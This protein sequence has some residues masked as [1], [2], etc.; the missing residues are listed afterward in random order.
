[1]FESQ[2]SNE[3]RQIRAL[4]SAI[5]QERAKARQLRSLKAKRARLERALETMRT[6]K[7]SPER[8]SY[9]DPR[10]ETTFSRPKG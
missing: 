6:P 2:I 7:Y 3:K 1:M 8:D 10:E 5:N 9:F 4:R